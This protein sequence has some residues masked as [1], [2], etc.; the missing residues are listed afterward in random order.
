MT[1]GNVWK[2]LTLWSLFRRALTLRLSRD[3]CVRL[4]S[5]AL[6]TCSHSSTVHANLSTT[7]NLSSPS[8]LS[9]AVYYYLSNDAFVFTTCDIA[10]AF[11]DDC[12]Q[13][14]GKTE[15]SSEANCWLSVLHN[16]WYALCFSSACFNLPHPAGWPLQ[17]LP[18]SGK[19]LLTSRGSPFQV[20][21]QP[22]RAT[23]SPHVTQQLLR[24]RRRNETAVFLYK[25]IFVLPAEQ[26]EELRNF[27]LSKEMVRNV[28]R[29]F[30]Y[31]QDPSDSGR[32]FI[33]PVS[34]ELF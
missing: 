10:G 20:N 16:K 7:G 24:C 18:S 12:R 27:T 11:K 15:V 9:N 28:F 25:L 34:L 6:L 23:V 8:F 3:V 22:T 17:V 33:D 29:Q 26:Q 5:S 4:C 1:T 32:M 13:N 31:D 21:T 30:L 19:I 2:R 14:C